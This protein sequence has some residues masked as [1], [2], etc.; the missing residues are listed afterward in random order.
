MVRDSRLA[1][2]ATDILFVG[3]AD[4]IGRCFSI[5]KANKEKP[6]ESLTRAKQFARYRA[7]SLRSVR[8]KGFEPL[9]YPT[10]RGRSTN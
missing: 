6:F 7:P 5:R 1:D 9:A 8:G 10:S 4:Y 2:V 3:F